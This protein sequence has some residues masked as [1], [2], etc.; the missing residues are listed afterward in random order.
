MQADVL[1]LVQA[2]SVGQAD[3]ILAAQF[4][5]QIV[6]SWSDKFYLSTANVLTLPSTATE[7]T[8]PPEMLA[9][10]GI[11]WDNTELGYCSLRELESL[12]PEW[13][14]RE[15]NPIAYNNDV[16]PAKTIALYPSPWT[17]SDPFT[18]G[19]PLG[20]A[21]PTYSV[22]LI[23]SE[24]RNDVPVYYELP[25]ALLILERLYQYESVYKDAELAMMWG[26]VGRLFLSMVS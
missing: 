11:I 24:S 23:G 6:D 19:D 14:N 20:A 3:P 15:G 18:G 25:L 17:K 21:Y 22:V 1:A 5:S 7:F 13:R 4:Y 12:D 9:L 10:K 26:E 8:M 2:L 16:G